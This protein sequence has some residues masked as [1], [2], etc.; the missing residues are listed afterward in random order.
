[1]MSTNIMKK[2]EVLL[3]A[4]YGEDEVNINSFKDS[5]KKITDLII[6]NHGRKKVALRIGSGY[7]SGSILSGIFKRI[8]HA[9]IVIVDFTS[10]KDLELNYNTVFE[11]GIAKYKEESIKKENPKYIFKVYPTLRSDKFKYFNK[12]LSDLAGEKINIYNNNYEF[13]ENFIKSLKGSI[14]LIFNK[15]NAL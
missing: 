2:V 6:D 15:K 3:F 7:F 9:D 11:Y 1:M 5:I 12:V 14:G 13:N 4:E 10:K 8:E